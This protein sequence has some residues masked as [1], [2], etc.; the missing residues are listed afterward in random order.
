M[1]V[2]VAIVCLIC[3][4]APAS[5]LEGFRFVFPQEPQ[6]IRAAP[7]AA[8]VL[9][10]YDKR[11]ARAEFDE[12]RENEARI[13]AIVQKIRAQELASK[14]PAVDPERDD[15][16]KY[17]ERQRMLAENEY[18]AEAHPQRDDFKAWKESAEYKSLQEKAAKRKAAEPVVAP[19]IDIRKWL[20]PPPRLE[21]TPR[22]KPVPTPEDE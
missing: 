16:R 13:L 5:A 3:S 8:R 21:K 10:E 6:P 11:A 1:R 15:Y 4:T 9:D 14:Q 20:N 17:L 2:A 19:E 7:A 18:Y 12:A 22:A